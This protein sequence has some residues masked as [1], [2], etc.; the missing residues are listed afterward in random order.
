MSYGSSTSNWKP[1]SWMTGLDQLFTMRDININS[2]LHQLTDFSNSSRSTKFKD[3]FPWNISHMI[4]RSVPISTR[5]A[6]S[7]A[8]KRD[9]PFWV[10]GK[11][12]GNWSKN[13]IMTKSLWW[14]LMSL[15]TNKFADDELTE[16]APFILGE[17]A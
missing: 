3:I 1:W 16:R 11:V 13:M 12:N 8:I 17:I 14:M 7:C 6:I 4:T 5:I 15:E 2:N 9:I 10:W